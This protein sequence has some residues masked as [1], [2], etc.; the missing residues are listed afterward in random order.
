MIP[1]EVIGFAIPDQFLR[2]ASAPG[3]LADGLNDLLRI[4]LNRIS[5]I[6]MHPQAAVLF[7]AE[8]A[9][10]TAQPAGNFVAAPDLQAAAIKILPGFTEIHEFFRVLI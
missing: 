5:N 3:R 6:K 8:H 10:H 1:V 4:S 9:L 7:L 2:K